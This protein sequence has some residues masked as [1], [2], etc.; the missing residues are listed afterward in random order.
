MPVMNWL[1]NM[2]NPDV[3]ERDAKLYQDSRQGQADYLA[4]MAGVR[5]A[6]AE[7]RGLGIKNQGDQLA[8]DQQKTLNV[9]FAKHFDPET[10][11]L[12]AVGFTA[13]A[14]KA[15]ILSPSAVQTPMA[16][17]AGALKTGEG[18]AES[19]YRIKMFDGDPSEITKPSMAP[20]AP[21]TGKQE[22]P[23]PSGMQGFFSSLGG[24]PQP[25][26]EYDPT[27]VIEAQ[28]KT[29]ESILGQ[30]GELAKGGLV[31]KAP[32]YR[33]L[34][35][36][37]ADKYLGVVPKKEYFGGDIAKYQAA[38]MERK[39]KEA[40]L[41][42]YLQEV[43]GGLASSG[44]S[45]AQGIQAKNQSATS[46]SQSQ[47]PIQYYREKEGIATSEANIGK[48]VDLFGRKK[49]L[50]SAMSEADKVLGKISKKE[51]SADKFAAE[52]TPLN[53]ALAFSEDVK[54]ENGSERL[55]SNF[56]NSKSFGSIASGSRGP[57]DLLTNAAR[58]AVSAQSQKEY[59]DLVKT[60]VDGLLRSG[61]TAS[62]IKALPRIKGRDA[63]AGKK[64]SRGR[65]E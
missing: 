10:Q 49:V 22:T 21:T 56:R 39:A 33:M 12:D 20:A 7:T 16:T 15:G 4:K 46:F 32:N 44:L 45:L 61:I 30:R 26:P 1:S 5:K 31:G 17:T 25:Q 3:S 60:T 19:A 42:A 48:V 34:L 50:E 63:D 35:K 62:Q 9:I 57:L 55:F 54:T 6:G 11:K 8:L 47:D 53:Q 28:A 36:A 13:D 64:Y 65:V 2:R 41:P 58:N 52:V 59:L 29:L 18:A 24:A 38:V 40:G 27:P 23:K 37:A 14:T 51:I 43:G